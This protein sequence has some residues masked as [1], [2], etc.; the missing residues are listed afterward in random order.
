MDRGWL[1]L[2]GCIVFVTLQAARADDVVFAAYNLENYFQAADFPD[3]SEKISKTPEAIAAEIHVIQDI[4][5]AILGVSEMGPPAEFAGFQ[6]RLKAAGLDYPASE[7]VAGPDPQRHVALLSKYP[8]VSRQSMADVPYEMDG[9][10]EKVCRGFLDVTIA[11]DGRNVRFIGVH[12]K[13]K[14]RDTRENEAAMRRNEAHLLRQHVND[15]LNADPGTSLV[16]YGDFNDTKNESCIKEVLGPRGSG[17]HLDDLWLKD[18]AG[19]HWTEY[20]NMAD[21]YSR[22]DY[23]L[24]THNLVSSVDEAR[25]YVYRSPY[26]NDASDHRA[27]V[28]SF[29]LG[30][31]Q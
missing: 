15:V 8:I 12:L 24:V 31:G 27:V 4:H 10:E 17:G 9:R 7:Y 26:W 18:S 30:S 6:A 29:R 2:L 23:I 21:E 25:S 22:I 28:A 14:L 13:S 20:W 1:W 11:V 16:V 19:D 5:P 3:G